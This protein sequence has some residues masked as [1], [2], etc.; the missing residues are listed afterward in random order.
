[1]RPKVRTRPEIEANLARLDAMVA[2]ELAGPICRQRRNALD[3]LY[4]KRREAVRELDAAID[5]S[6][7]R[8][9]DVDALRIH[10]AMHGN[11][12]EES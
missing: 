12:D 7:C 2:D 8:D 4:A 6:R 5:A 1:M 3:L 11:G 9:T 10:E